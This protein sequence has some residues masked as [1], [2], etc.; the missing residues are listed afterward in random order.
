MSSPWVT[1]FHDPATGTITYVAAD[2]TQRRAAVIDPV[3]D[4]EPKSGRLSTRSADRL[5]AFLEQEKLALDWILETHV[6]ADHLSA[7]QLLKHRCPPGSAVGAAPPPPSSRTPVV[8][9][10]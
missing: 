10:S 6:H 9:T 4:F 1:G 3:W 5:S 8:R 2:R 7:A